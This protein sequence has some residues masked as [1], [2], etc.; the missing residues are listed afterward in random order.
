MLAAGGGYGEKKTDEGHFGERRFAD[1][2]HVRS[3][4]SRGIKDDSLLFSL[5]NWAD[6]T[7]IR[8]DVGGYNRKKISR[9]FRKFF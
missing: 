3:E 4:A 5:R 1:G 7:A 6:G 9:K 2:W 8:Q